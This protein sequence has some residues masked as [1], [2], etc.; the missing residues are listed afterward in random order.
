M[1]RLVFVIATILMTG[2]SNLARVSYQIEPKDDYSES[3]L[4]ELITSLQKTDEK[5]EKYKVTRY[6]PLTLS[7]GDRLIV[8]IAEDE[9]FSGMYEINIDGMLTLPFVSQLS[10]IGKTVQQVE[11]EITNLLVREKILK[12]SLAIVSCRIQQ[13]SAIKVLVSG[14]VF[15]PG[16]VMINNRSIEHKNY[17]Q[18]QKNGDS[19][20]E[21]FLTTAIRSAGGVRPDADLK[22]V[23][24]IRNGLVNEYD[25]SGILFGSQYDDIPLIAGDQVII[26]SLGFTQQELMRPSSITPPGF[27]IF[28]SNLST[29]GDSNGKSAI[30]KEARSIPFGTRLLRGLIS[31]NCVGGTVSTNASRVA[32]LVTTDLLTGQTRVI[33]RSIEELVRNYNRDEFNPYLMPNDGLACYDSNVTNARDVARSLSEIFNPLLMLSNFGEG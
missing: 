8:D 30:G 23:Q 21:R 25:I 16:G 33:Q 24:V 15:S 10:V 32:V 26:P 22:K 9:Y 6:T 17:L 29:P 7:P 27:S 4:V 1:F 3:E 5:T 31:A 11:Y 18:T 2:C 20:F 28:I 13:W 19:S 14:S 12:P